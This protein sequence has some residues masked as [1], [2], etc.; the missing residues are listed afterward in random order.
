MNIRSQILGQ[1]GLAKS[2]LVCIK[3]PKGARSDDLM[4][5][6]VQ[7]QE[8]RQVDTR[9]ERRFSL[10]S[11]K[12]RVSRDRGAHDVQLLNVCGAGAMVTSTFE[13][14]LW[15]RLELHLGEHG[16]IDCSVVWIKNGRIGLEFAVETRLDCAEDEQASLLREVIHRHFPE[17]HFEAPDRPE[18]RTSDE[19]RQEFRHAFAW[20]GTLHC[21]YGSTPAR[22]RN[23]SPDGALIETSFELMAGA[24]PF[25][26]LGAAGSIA[27]TI[28]WAEGNQSGLK[29]HRRFDVG[30]LARAKPELVG[31]ANN[32]I[33]FGSP[34][35]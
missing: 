12:S 13:P 20:S 34:R 9:L 4:S 15:E 35:R 30:L 2:P 11:E 6:R 24:E 26:D 27:G 1:N 7:R 21:E 3:N 28:V 8:S 16:T 17:V 14:A 32:I 25:L 5:I 33:Q 10:V 22:L 29:F 23:I 19:H 31:R 18:A